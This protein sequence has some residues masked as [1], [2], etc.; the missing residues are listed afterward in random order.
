MNKKWLSIP[1]VLTLSLTMAGTAFAAWGGSYGGSTVTTPAPAP[2]P[3]PAA[4]SALTTLTGT[5]AAVDT[6]N[7]TLKVTDASG[8]ETIYTVASTVTINILNDPTPKTLADIKV[9]DTVVLSFYNKVLKDI[10]VTA[11]A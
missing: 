3:A 1:L 5:V 11:R 4:P 10:D 2:A 9:G 8:V 6:V 7:S